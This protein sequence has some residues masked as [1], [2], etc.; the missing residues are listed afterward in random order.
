MYF[1]GAKLRMYF[2]IIICTIE[3]INTIQYACTK[4]SIIFQMYF[5]VY[6]VMEYSFNGTISQKR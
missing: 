3:S 6:T 4:L 5:S 1:H 2:K